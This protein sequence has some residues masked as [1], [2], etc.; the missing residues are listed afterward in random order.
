MLW[1][2]RRWSENV[3]HRPAVL[4][5]PHFDRECGLGGYY[6]HTP[7][8]LFGFHVHTVLKTEHH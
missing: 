1:L 6:I 5:R 8:P 4:L 2:D 3:A 7:I